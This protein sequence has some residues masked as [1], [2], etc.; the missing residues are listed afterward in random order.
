MQQTIP[1]PDFVGD[2]EQPFP[3]GSSQSLQ[4]MAV[5][6]GGLYA[7]HA[8]TYLMQL[9]QRDTRR[10]TVALLVGLCQSVVIVNVPLT[11]LCVRYSRYP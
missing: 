10:V 8:I 1:E 7:S 2:P 11:G 5:I 3:V 9:R 4:P 6:G